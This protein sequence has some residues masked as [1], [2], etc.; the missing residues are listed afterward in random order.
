MSENPVLVDITGGVATITMNCERNR[1]ALTAAMRSGLREAFSA[2]AAESDA[3]AILL[4]HTGTVFCAG[5]DLREA[6]G[7]P[8]AGLDDFAAL[9]DQVE[10]SPVPVVAR[11]AGPAR[12]GGLGFVAAADIAVAVDTATFAFSEVRLGVVPAMISG[13]VLDRVTSRASREL[14]LTGRTFNAAEAATIGLINTA[15][16]ADTLD[17]VVRGYL[18]TL[19]LGEPHALA[20]TKSLVTR[21]HN[22]RPPTA[23]LVSLSQ[24]FF[25]SPEA[26]E[27]I[28]AF[29]EKRAPA[30]V[31]PA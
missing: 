5:M 26:K 24:T 14:M 18:D 27:G 4:T 31:L 23:E 6:A 2:A 17:D 3:R 11:L 13:A 22:Q 12:A 25:T 19:I 16:P 8:R 15:V 20:A 7:D 29:T 30:W 1:N 21:T 28:R 9:L 10:H